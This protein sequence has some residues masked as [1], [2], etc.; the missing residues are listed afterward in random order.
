MLLIIALGLAVIYALTRPFSKGLIDTGNW[1]VRIAMAAPDRRDD[2]YKESVIAAQA[3]LQG[4]WF[5]L[6][7][8]VPY[9]IFFTGMILGFIYHWWGGFVAFGTG[10]LLNIVTVNYLTPSLFYYLKLYHKQLLKEEKEWKQKAAKEDAEEM[11]EE[12]EEKEALVIEEFVKHKRACEEAL[13]IY[14]DSRL[15]PPTVEDL[16]GIPYGDAHYLIENYAL[17]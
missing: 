1:L 10:Y 7:Q 6:F 8:V 13:V 11:E 4:G 12:E 16:D 3:N 9:L 5:I 17:E 15:K 14:K 2:K